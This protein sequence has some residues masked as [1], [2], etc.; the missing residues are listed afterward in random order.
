MSRT[1]FPI[2]DGVYTVRRVKQSDEYPEKDTVFLN[3]GL[4]SFRADHGEYAE[5]DEIRVENG[6]AVGSPDSE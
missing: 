2:D 5:G 1:G 3:T 6:R 4:A